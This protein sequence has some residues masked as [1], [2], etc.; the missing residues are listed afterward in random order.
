MSVHIG[1]AVQGP[2]GEAARGSLCAPLQSYPAPSEGWLKFWSQ[3]SLV[4]T[5]EALLQRGVFVYKGSVFKHWFK[6]AAHSR[7]PFPMVIKH[8]SGHAYEFKKRLG[9]GG[10]GYVCEMACASPAK[11]MPPALALKLFLTASE[12]GD[13][14]MSLVNQMNIRDMSATLGPQTDRIPACT[15][16]DISRP[17]CVV[18]ALAV[19]GHI[20][21]GPHDRAGETWGAEEAQAIIRAATEEVHNMH[22]R[23]NLLCYDTKT[24][25]FL[26]DRTPEGRVIVRASD[27]GGYGRPGQFVCAT[28]PTPWLATPYGDGSQKLCED[29]AVYG[30]LAMY[31]CL[32][33]GT[34]DVLVHYNPTLRKDALALFSGLKADHSLLLEEHDIYFDPWLH[35]LLQAY[36][37]LDV[38]TMSW[39]LHKT[40]TLAGLRAAMDD[41]ASVAKEA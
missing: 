33:W 4:V 5:D 19:G 9:K 38:E 18:M 29:M 7:P 17:C 14:E 27:Y 25:N 10:F 35:R 40:L 15:M 34:V 21:K 6:R 23:Y 20:A 12:E 13:N 39:D 3:L 41:A 30:L 31:L 2:L 16:R 28:F 11:G 26:V 32:R 1:A 22:L 24:L 36:L 37:P 8:S